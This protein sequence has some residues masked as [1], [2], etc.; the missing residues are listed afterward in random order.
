MGICASCCGSGDDAGD[1]DSERQGLINGINSHPQPIEPVAG[2]YQR[3]SSV[4]RKNDEQ[5][6]MNRIIHKAASNVIDV[7]ALDTHGMEHHEFSERAK[8]YN[9]KLNNA[10]LQLRTRLRKKEI[11]P[12]NSIPVD[13]L[14]AFVPL[15]VP[16]LEMINN[17]SRSM[18]EAFQHFA[19]NHTE[20]LIVQFPVA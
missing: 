9:L 17:L 6:A 19:V 14:A 13:R 8:T 3:T 5:S 15:P 20:D 10:G 4:I 2:D 18:D 11:L 12:E 16:D 1:R 7:A